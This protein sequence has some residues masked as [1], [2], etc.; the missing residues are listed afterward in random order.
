[1]QETWVQSLGWEDSLEERVG[2]PLQYSCHEKPMDRGTWQA[3]VY[4]AAKSWTQLSKRTH[5]SIERKITGDGEVQGEVSNTGEEPKEKSLISTV[6]FLKSTYDLD[7]CEYKR[8][9]CKL[10]WRSVWVLQ[11]NSRPSRKPHVLDMLILLW[12]SKANSEAC[13][14]ELCPHYSLSPLWHSLS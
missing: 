10:T 11:S 2:N 5:T 9:C 13:H 12:D 3:T 7:F 4:R 8:G 14:C 1:M 6:F